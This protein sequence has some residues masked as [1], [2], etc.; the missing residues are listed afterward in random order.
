MSHGTILNVLVIILALFLIVACLFQVK[1]TGSGLFGATYSTFRT[2]RGF[3]RLLFRA[4]IV[5][6]F[7]FVIASIAAARWK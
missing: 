6:S 1:G 3:E 7:L 4:T 2:R 5:V